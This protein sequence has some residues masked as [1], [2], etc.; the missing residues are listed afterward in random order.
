MDGRY[1]EAEVYLR[2]ARAANPLEGD[3][4]AVLAGTFLRQRRYSDAEAAI[5]TALRA[6][7]YK[8]GYRRVLAL[9]L[10]GQSKFAEAMQA[11]TIEHKTTPKTRLPSG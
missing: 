6:M 2:K 5:S 7:P 1:E 8:P 9:S 11:A 4:S 3:P 10:E